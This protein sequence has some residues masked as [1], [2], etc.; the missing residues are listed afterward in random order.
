M[1]VLYNATRITLNKLL[2]FSPDAVKLDQIIKAVWCQ[3]PG[4]GILVQEQR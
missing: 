4:K 3:N 2:G 1:P